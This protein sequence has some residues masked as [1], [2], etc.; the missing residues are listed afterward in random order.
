MS[1][2]LPHSAESKLVKQF[3]INAIPRYMLVDKYGKVIDDDAPR[4]SDKEI[5]G[6]LDGLLK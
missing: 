1:F 6:V 3:K 2:L 5:R 4:P